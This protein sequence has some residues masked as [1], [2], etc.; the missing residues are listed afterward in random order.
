MNPSRRALLLAATFTATGCASLP[1]AA[2]AEVRQTLA[3][4]GKLR[5][6]VLPGSPASLVRDAATGELR[7]VAVEL[8]AELARRLGV[9]CEFVEFGAFSAVAGALRSAAADIATFNFSSA[10]ARDVLLSRVLFSQESGYLAGPGSAIRSIAQVDQAGVRIGVQQNSTSQS[11]LKNVI[12]QARLVPVANLREVPQMLVAREFDVF[13]TNKGI[14]YD[15]AQRAPGST[16]LEG[17]YTSET[18][19]LA[20]PKGRENALPYLNAFLD[21]A[22][23]SGLFARVVERAH[24]RGVELRS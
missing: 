2:P 1:A 8:G 11:V 6:A 10:F 19:G 23:R 15:L 18:Q 20:I 9:P 22:V 12:R 21:E 3:P 13:A 17:S 7:G 24:L 16:M 4:A 5:V 14:L